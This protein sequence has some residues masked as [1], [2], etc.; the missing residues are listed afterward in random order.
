[1]RKFTSRTDVPIDVAARVAAGPPYNGTV[2]PEPPE[3]ALSHVLLRYYVL[4]LVIRGP[5]TKLLNQ[6]VTCLTEAIL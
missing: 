4:L 3:G 1:M 2:R 5:K 6:A